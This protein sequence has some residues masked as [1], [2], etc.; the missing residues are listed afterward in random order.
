MTRTYTEKKPSEKII[1]MARKKL[2]AKRK[3]QRQPNNKVQLL[4]TITIKRQR[5]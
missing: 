4:M 5:Q 2:R 3:Q 1:S